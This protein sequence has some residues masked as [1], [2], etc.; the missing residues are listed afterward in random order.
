MKM[1]YTD[2]IIAVRNAHAGVLSRPVSPYLCDCIELC[3]NDRNLRAPFLLL[4]KERIGGRF[5]VPDHLFGKRF[6]HELTEGQRAE[7]QE[8]RNTLLDELET[9]ANNLDGVC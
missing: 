6:D 5:S 4:I 1:S 9:L 2:M 7:A 8:F 3:I